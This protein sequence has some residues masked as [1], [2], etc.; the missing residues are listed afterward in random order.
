MGKRNGKG[1]GKS[2]G[3]GNN[4]AGLKPAPTRKSRS[5]SRIPTLAK[6]R[7][8]G[9][10]AKAK[11][12]ATAK[13]RESAGCRR[14]ESYGNGDGRGHVDGNGRSQFDARMPRQASAGTRVANVHGQKRWQGT[15]LHIRFLER[16]DGFG[17]AA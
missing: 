7:E 11:A 4:R 8:D 6:M 1:K 2:N 10:P 16:V 12:T 5:K 13:A 17:M 3:K 9:A 15:A 14:Y